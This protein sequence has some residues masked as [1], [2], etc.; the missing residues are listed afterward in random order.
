VYADDGVPGQRLVASA[1]HQRRGIRHGI[2]DGD[3]I[4][5][6]AEPPCAGERDER[7]DGADE[8]HLHQRVAPADGAGCALHG[9]TLATPR[10]VRRII[11]P[12]PTAESRAER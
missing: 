1:R 11:A 10:I 8:H 9:C 4:E 6:M 3:P 7:D 2:A 12:P 5:V